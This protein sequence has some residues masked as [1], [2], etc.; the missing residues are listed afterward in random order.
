MQTPFTW[1]CLFSCSSQLP[2]RS[3]HGS[4][5]DQVRLHCG[6]CQPPGH[7]GGEGDEVRGENAGNAWQG[8]AAETGSQLP[9][10]SGR[11]NCPALNSHRPGTSPCWLLGLAGWDTEDITTTTLSFYTGHSCQAVR[12][13][14][15]IMD[16]L[17][18]RI[19]WTS[20]E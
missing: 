17:P 3:Q 5:S 7:G 19:I 6:P 13:Q 16:I 10:C 2:H 9:G 4:L 1:R 15:L 8:R 11:T 18:T 20:W 14:P 12:S